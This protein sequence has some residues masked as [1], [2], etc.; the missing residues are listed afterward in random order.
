MK[1]ALTGGAYQARS[2]IASAQRSVNLFSEPM[3]QGQGGG[4]SP[5]QAMVLA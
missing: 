2:V 1:Q 4:A 3:P 5:V